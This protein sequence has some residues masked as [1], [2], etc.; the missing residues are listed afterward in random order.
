MPFA[1]QRRHQIWSVDLRYLDMH[2]ASPY[3]V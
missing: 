1:A 2:H 3:D